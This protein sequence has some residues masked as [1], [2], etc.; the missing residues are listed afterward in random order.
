V[1]SVWLDRAYLREELQMI[2]KIFYCAFT[3]FILSTHMYCLGGIETE[4][5]T[6]KSINKRMPGKAPQ[7][8]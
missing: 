1:V 6:P 8:S 5:K 2:F 3:F 4:K 7:G